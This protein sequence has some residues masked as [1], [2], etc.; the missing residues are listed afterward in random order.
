MADRLLLDL[1]GP[2]RR[3]ARRPE[4]VPSP[5]PRR[6]RR[7]DRWR[8]LGIG[9]GLSG[10]GGGLLASLMFIPERFDTLLLVSTAIANVI[11][12]LSRLGVGLLQLTGVLV[13]ALLALLALVLL[14]GGMVRMARCLASPPLNRGAAATR[15]QPV[16][17]MTRE[18]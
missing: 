17:K 2:P 1:P 4:A 3:L 10:A 8:H 15:S 13:V 16:A 6:R 5:N 9:L 14:L 7:P 12:G 18:R 11:G